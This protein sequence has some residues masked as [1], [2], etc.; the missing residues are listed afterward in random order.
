MT[1]IAF[2]CWKNRE[3]VIRHPEKYNVAYMEEEEAHCP[4]GSVSAGL[5]RG[6]SSALR[7]TVKA[8]NQESPTWHAAFYTQ[9]FS[10]I[11]QLS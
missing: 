1:G 2:K 8:K 5:K 10:F 11:D 4:R 3:W 7:M 6:K 9:S